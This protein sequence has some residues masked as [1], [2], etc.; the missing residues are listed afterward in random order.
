MMILDDV[1]I[2][3]AQLLDLGLDHRFA[4]VIVGILDVVVNVVLFSRVH[5]ASWFYLNIFKWILLA[6]EGAFDIY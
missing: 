2:L 5:L 6:R 3:L 4:V 1:L